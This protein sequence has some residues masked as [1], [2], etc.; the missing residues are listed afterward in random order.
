MRADL[1]RWIERDPDRMRLYHTEAAYHAHVTILSV[2]LDGV[3]QSLEIARV[4]R[5]LIDQAINAAALAAMER[6]ET[7]EQR[8][9]ELT[10]QINAAS[11]VPFGAPLLGPDMFSDGPPF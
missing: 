6:Q 4:P 11:R 5:E 8:Q 9:H 3:E 10:K 7:A 2:V 1:Q